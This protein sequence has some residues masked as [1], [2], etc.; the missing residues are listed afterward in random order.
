MSDLEV[1]QA[2]YPDY[3]AITHHVV[4]TIPVEA[5]AD[6][7]LASLPPVVITLD[8][9]PPSSPSTPST[10]GCTTPTSPLSTP[11]CSH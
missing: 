5:T 4:L 11:I 6:Q 7:L 10:T 8:L 3:L 9:P 2:I 1:I